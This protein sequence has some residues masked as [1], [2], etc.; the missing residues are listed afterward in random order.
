MIYWGGIGTIPWFS[1][2]VLLSSK[3]PHLF[4]LMRPVY[5]C[6]VRLTECHSGSR[7]IIVDPE[8]DPGKDGDKYRRHVCLQDEVPNVSLQLK[9]QGQARISTWRRSKE[10]CRGNV[11]WY[12]S[13]ISS[14]AAEETG[15][16]FFNHA[17]LH[18]ISGYFKMPSDR[19]KSFNG[20]GKND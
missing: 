4:Q 15:L 3:C 6:I 10:V 16:S 14:T 5:I 2:L 12:I 8:G 1:L 9:T 20:H 17:I 19:N 13:T 18:L 7:G 11:N